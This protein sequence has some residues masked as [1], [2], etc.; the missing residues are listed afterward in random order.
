MALEQGSSS[1][2]MEFLGRII[3]VETYKPPMYV[4][5]P[6]LI[7]MHGAQR[8]AERYRNYATLVAT[9]YNCLVAVPHLSP[10]KF[11]E[12]E[13]YQGNLFPGSA[14]DPATDAL[15]APTTLNPQEDWTLHV[16][17]RVLE[18]LREKEQNQYLA[19][20]LFGH[21]A[22]AQFVVCFA[23]FLYPLLDETTRPVRM[24]VANGAIPIFPGNPVMKQSAV[25]INTNKCYTGPNRQLTG[26]K[27]LPYPCSELSGTLNWHYAYPKNPKVLRDKERI[28]AVRPGEE[29]VFPYGFKNVLP[30]P[31]D[32]DTFLRCPLV[33]FPGDRDVNVNGGINNYCETIDGLPPGPY[34]VAQ[35]PFRLFKILNC[36]LTGQAVAKQRKVKCNWKIMVAEGVG[37]NGAA[38]LGNV[39]AGRAIF[40]CCACR[41]RKNKFYQRQYVVPGAKPLV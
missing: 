13:Y 3:T 18:R 1:F 34:A 30:A 15:I 41:F 29:L 39:L 38:S 36:Y 19:Y 32:V 33:F 7:V 35:G 11:S 17:V 22:G 23:A 40:G 28:R 16:V 25:K 37:H 6:V 5:Q 9:Q 4:A 14:Y 10:E 12:T 27:P 8:D 24:S 20:Y 21:G 2:E 26:V 31:P